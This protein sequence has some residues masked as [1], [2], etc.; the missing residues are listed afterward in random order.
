MSMQESPVDA[1]DTATTQ[2]QAHT[3]G[4][5]LCSCAEWPGSALDTGAIE[6][7][8]MPWA[9]DLLVV[10]HKNL[11][12][13]PDRVAEL[14]ARAR[15][16]GAVIPSCAERAGLAHMLRRAGALP[17]A[18]ETIDLPESAD[19]PGATPHVMQQLAAAVVRVHGLL[20][21]MPEHLQ[22]YYGPQGATFDRR[23]LLRSLLEPTYRVVPAVETSRCVASQGCRLCLAA[24][25]E[26]ALRV[27]P[28]SVT[29]SRDACTACGACVPTCPSQAITWPGFGLAD[30][31]AQL[32]VL[33]E[34]RRGSLA[35][36][37]L[38][39]ACTGSAAE[40]LQLLG[41]L[42]TVPLDAVVLSV[43]CAS[44]ISPA[45]L[46]R[47]FERGAQGV[48]VVAC[49]G[50][51]PHGHDRTRIRQTVS[52]VTTVL[53]TL[54]IGGQRLAFI[55]GPMDGSGAERFSRREEDAT[56]CPAIQMPAQGQAPG[57]GQDLS[58]PAILSRLAAAFR[59]SPPTIAGEDV[60]FGQVRV[61]GPM[62]C[63]LCGVCAQACPTQA[64]G[65]AHNP[66]GETLTFRHA[67]CVACGTCVE[68]C[69][70]KVLHL[71]RTLDF[72]RLGGPGEVLA[73]TRV[74]RCRLCQQVIA[75]ASM[76]ARVQQTLRSLPSGALWDPSELCA[77]CRLGVSVGANANVPI[78]G[79]GRVV[80]LPDGR[81]AHA[82][83]APGE[84]VE[85]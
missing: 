51:C 9:P 40:S 29:V 68:Q 38:L 5:F 35:P 26:G 34:R 25:P 19:T 77:S 27:G 52:F 66:I 61:T 42:G 15:V 14:L 48:A 85:G 1:R 7:L 54:S 60:P 45:L 10:V 62:A 65:L 37:L 8:L 17:W 75:S 39:L 59:P 20:R 55:E 81:G 22:V 36:R 23:A 30:L 73:R 21:A 6:R 63:T 46:L 57:G 84:E 11:C 83:G 80:M 49:A 32:A 58:L 33:L 12:H 74:I 28:A 69:P 2:R 82:A 24:C 18:I 64:L 3:L 67:R 4:L 50:V 79:D 72:G 43:P 44:L 31:D 53:A 76:L 13:A 78:A 70:E 56:A 16:A 71:D 47:A 41:D